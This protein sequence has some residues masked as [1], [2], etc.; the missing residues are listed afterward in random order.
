MLMILN[1]IFTYPTLRIHADTGKI[2]MTLYL[3]C[4]IPLEIKSKNKSSVH[5][6]IFKNKWFDQS[7]LF[8]TKQAK[9]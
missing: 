6:I 5:T 8:T 7:A 4:V 3:K 1:L 2:L 9:F